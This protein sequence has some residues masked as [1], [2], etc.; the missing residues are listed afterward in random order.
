MIKLS[1]MIYVILFPFFRFDDKFKIK[2][3]KLIFAIIAIFALSSCEKD[4]SVNSIQPTLTIIGKWKLD[5]YQAIL[6]GTVSTLYVGIPDDYVE[7]KINKTYVMSIAANNSV[8]SGIYELNG[9]ILTFDTLDVWDITN[10]TSNNLIF[11]RNEISNA[12]AERYIF[13]LK[14]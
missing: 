11:E 12:G 6:N 2:M 13:Y 7:F 3:K 9:K 14:R 5:K 1:N 10:H 4:D 8:D